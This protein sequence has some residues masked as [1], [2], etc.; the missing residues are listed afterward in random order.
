MAGNGVNWM[1]LM[2]SAQRKLGE[3]LPMADTGVMGPSMAEA[4]LQGVGALPSNPAGPYGPFNSAAQSQVARNWA[5]AAGPAQAANPP[6]GPYG[7]FNQAAQGG[8]LAQASPIV[9]NAPLPQRPLPTMQLPQAPTPAPAAQPLPTWEPANVQSALP[10]RAAGAPNPQGPY[11]PFNAAAQVE[12]PAG[13]YGPFNAQNT[14]Q[15]HGPASPNTG[16]WDTLR[17][18]GGTAGSGGSR[19][20]EWATNN[21]NQGKYGK[22]IRIGESLVPMVAWGGAGQLVNSAD[23]NKSI[24]PVD[25]SVLQGTTLGGTLGAFGGVPGSLAGAV[26]VGTAD[27]ALNVAGGQTEN[28][29]GLVAAGKTA[30]R[31]VGGL[32]GGIMSAGDLLNTGGGNVSDLFNSDGILGFTGFGGE[33]GDGASAEEAPVTPQNTIDRVFDVANLPSDRRQMLQSLYDIRVAAGEKP[34][35][36]AT[37]IKSQTISEWQ[38]VK[39]EEKQLGALAAQQAQAQKY[40]APYLDSMRAQGQQ[41]QQLLQAMLPNLP[42]QMQAYGQYAANSAPMQANQMADAYAAQVALAP[43]QMMQQRQQE[44]ATS[45][46]NQYQQQMDQAM[47]QAQIDASGVQPTPLS[48][49]I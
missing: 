19:L 17:G 36:V 26:G 22:A 49:G 42:A 5:Q 25:K 34:E 4:Q 16:F 43:S 37:D 39:D 14:G 3:G 29:S 18:R 7:P 40:M 35:D 44:R 38:A 1:Q 10:S 24:G 23:P 46:A 30:L 28:D 45:L 6:V 11:G 33:G 41:S 32:A 13:P 21:L 31:G 27:T 15:M 12:T 2:R 48:S 8:G 20:P 47:I 9:P